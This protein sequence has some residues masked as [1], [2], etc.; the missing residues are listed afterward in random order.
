MSC[1]TASWVQDLP[2]E[3]TV[4][5]ASGVLIE[6]NAQAELIFKDDGGGSLLGTDAL[7]C[8][9]EPS[10]TKF[11]G[12]LEVQNPN[13]YLNTEKGEKRFFFQSPWYIAGRFAGFV[14]IS[15]EVPGEIPQLV[16]E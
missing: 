13:A 1:S 6:M 4:C 16:K 9:P 7:A 12:M 2:A 10:R 5:D 8:H 15:F 14:E 11:A 3:I